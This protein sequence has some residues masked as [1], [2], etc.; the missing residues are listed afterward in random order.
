MLIVRRRTVALWVDCAIVLLLFAGA[1]IWGTA[2]W[3]R[4]VAAG[5]PFYYQLYFEPAVMVACGRG[6]VVAQPQVPAMVEFLW[7][8][9]TG[10]RAA[11]PPYIL[12]TDGFIRPRGGT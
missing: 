10:S 4:A 7:R 1:T 8:R 11:I 9:P 12:G 3:K 2:H 5:Q 6:F